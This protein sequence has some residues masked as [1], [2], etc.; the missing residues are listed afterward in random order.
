MAKA[1]YDDANLLL[2]LYEIRREE[3][4]RAARSWFVANFKAKTMAEWNAICG[5]GTD[6]NPLFRQATS[7]WDMVAS[8]VASGVLNE[9]LLFQSTRELLL[10]WLRLKP[11]ANEARAALKDPHAWKNL[12]TVGESFAKYLGP[13]TLAAFAARIGA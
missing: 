3:K 9:E 7:Y 5:P 8:F 4:L 6:A 1:T 2:R 13:E 10:F 11:I 12:E